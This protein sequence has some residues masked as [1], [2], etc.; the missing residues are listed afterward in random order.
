MRTLWYLGRAVANAGFSSLLAGL[1]LQA[2]G[3]VFQTFSKMFIGII[4]FG[5]LHALVLLPVVALNH[6]LF[7]YMGYAYLGSLASFTGLIYDITIAYTHMHATLGGKMHHLHS[8]E[9]DT[10]MVAVQGE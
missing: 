4:L 5:L 2:G 9:P 10:F 1:C 8:Y 6:V 7:I 3:P